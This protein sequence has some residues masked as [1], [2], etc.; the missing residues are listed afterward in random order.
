MTY[1]TSTEAAAL[2]FIGDYIKDTG[3]VSPTY[4]EIMR[5]IGHRS[6]SK[7]AFVLDGLE[8]KGKIKRLGF[9]ARAIE[10]ID[11]NAPKPVVRYP[12]ATYFKFDDET[13]E[14]VPWEP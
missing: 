13:K 7:I 2:E 4:T 9:R 10:V 6:K 1:L 8:R 3:G 11:P 14:L 12:R 5:V